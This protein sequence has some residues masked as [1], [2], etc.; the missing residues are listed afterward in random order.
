MRAV[1]G[2]HILAVLLLLRYGAS[3]SIVDHEGHGA[4]HWAVFH[5][6]HV[7]VEW[8]LKEA[9]VCKLVSEADQKGKTP[10]HLAASKSGREMVRVAWRAPLLPARWARTL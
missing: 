6:H 9:A 8:L 7:V 2:G 5:R 1:Q 3:T 4:L 10:L